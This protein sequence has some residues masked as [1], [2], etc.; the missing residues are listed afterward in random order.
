MELMQLMETCSSHRVEAGTCRS[1][2]VEAGTCRSHRVE[3]GTPQGLCS[4]GQRDAGQRK[5]SQGYR[6]VVCEEVF[7][8]YQIR[9]HSCITD[10]TRIRVHSCT[11]D[12][13][14]RVEAGT[15]SHRLQ[16]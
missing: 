6:T 7:L 16:T 12:T 15:W 8:G 14:Y 2:R 1:H 9:V 3:A 10:E 5:H 11:A 4:S 13:S